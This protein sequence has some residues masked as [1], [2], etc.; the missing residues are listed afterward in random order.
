MLSSRTLFISDLHLQESRPDIT[1]TLLHF[2]KANQGQSDA[3][4]ILGDLFEVWIGD[5]DVS[6]LKSTIARALAAFN[7]AGSWIFIA[8]GNRDFLIGPDYAEQC[9]ATLIEDPYILSSESDSV[10]LLHG[11]QLCIDDSEYMKF[12]NQVR[13]PD[14]Q[15]EFLAKSLDF[16]RA[17]AS[18]ARQQSQSAI[19][20]NP[21]EIMDVN[22]NEVLQL[23]NRS[24]QTT[25]IHGHT[26]RPEIHQIQLDSPIC[27]RD[28]AKRIVLGD[29]DQRGWFA[30]LNPDGISLQNFPLQTALASK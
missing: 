17:F 26:H 28:E 15:R 8:H 19:A 3:L 27:E 30:E 11:D 1:A 21:I 6:E 20:D 29:W 18:Q 9:G 25:I 7:R 13:D 23:L 16:R 14:W 2:L 4:F 10:V 22:Q 12:R 24:Q 5:D